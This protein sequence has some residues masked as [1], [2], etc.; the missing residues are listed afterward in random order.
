[1]SAY[2]PPPRRAWLLVS[3]DLAELVPVML[4]T[5]PV[6]VAKMPPPL[7]L[8]LFV[9][10]LPDRVEL[11]T[12]TFFAAYTPPPLPLVAVLL[13]TVAEVSVTEPPAE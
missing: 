10:V 9:A 6:P 3:V 5:V 2:T 7:P 12:V 13:L 11:V 1:M 4:T 8:V